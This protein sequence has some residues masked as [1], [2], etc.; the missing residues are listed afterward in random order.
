MDVK[1]WINGP[2]ADGEPVLPGRNYLYCVAFSGERGVK[3]VDLSSDNDTT[4]EAAELVGPDLGPDAWRTFK[5]ELDLPL[6]KSR[7]VSRATDMTGDRPPRKRQENHRG[8]GNPGWE[9]A[10]LGINVVSELPKFVSTLKP[11]IASE[12]CVNT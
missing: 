1:S 10:G 8:Y 9:D 5:F 6:G 7:Y 4:W 2:G 11:A 12:V 3:H